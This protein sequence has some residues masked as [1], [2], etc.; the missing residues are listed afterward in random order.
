MMDPEAISEMG[1]FVQEWGVD[2]IEEGGEVIDNVAEGLQQTVHAVFY[3][4]DTA[5]KVINYFEGPEAE[6]PPAF[7][8]PMEEEVTMRSSSVSHEDPPPPAT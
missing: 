1:Q 4:V 7:D 6:A 2:V 5:K 8:I 3:P